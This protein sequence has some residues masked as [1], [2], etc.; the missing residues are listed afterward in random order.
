MHRAD[1]DDFTR[2]R[3]GGRRGDAD[4]AARVRQRRRERVVRGPSLLLVVQ[5]VV[6]RWVPAGGN[7]KV[8]G[9]IPRGIDDERIHASRRVDKGGVT[10]ILSPPLLT[11]CCTA[12]STPTAHAGP[13]PGGAGHKC[14]HDYDGSRSRGSDS[15]CKLVFRTNGGDLRII[16]TIAIV[17]TITT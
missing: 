2:S 14:V 6:V 3:D 5:S 11:R 4:G 13:W 9:S 7:V 1:A 8:G 10:C 15:E 12:T 16:A 17:T